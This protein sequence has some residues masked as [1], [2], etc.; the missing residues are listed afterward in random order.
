MNSD[1]KKQ[2]NIVLL[3]IVALIIFIGYRFGFTY[4]NDKAEELKKQNE[5]YQEEVTSLQLMN[6]KAA[7]Y[8][9]SINESK[10]HIA[11]IFN[12]YGPGVTPEKSSMFVIGL[13]NS[14]NIAVSNIS[15]G[16]PSVMFYGTDIPG[17]MGLPVVATN[18]LMSLSYKTTYEGL[19]KCIKYITEYP[20]RMNIQSLNVSY[21]AETGNLSGNLV[22]RQYAVVSELK[23][24]VEPDIN[25]MKIGKENIFG[26]SEIWNNK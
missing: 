19:K 21:D 24:Y 7:M 14:A 12:Q 11:D 5:Q 3:L 20:E 13:E 15:F 22:L 1:I 6:S 17:A 16:E 25:E 4:F 9:T 18:T 26:T 8:Q 23:P 10:E 2:T